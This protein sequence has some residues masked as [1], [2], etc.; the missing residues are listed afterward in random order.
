M[1]VNGDVVPTVIS[2][3]RG[4]AALKRETSRGSEVGIH[5]LAIVPALKREDTMV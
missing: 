3:K 1:G 2:P 4:R 5:E